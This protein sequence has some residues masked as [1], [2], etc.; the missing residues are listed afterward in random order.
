MT[1]LLTRHPA[2]RWAIGSVLA[3]IVLAAAYHWLSAREQADDT[4]NQQIG[5]QQE[6]GEAAQATI[7]Q[8]RKANDAEQELRSDDAV[9]RASCLR[10]SRNPENCR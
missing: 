2:L 4:T 9:R 10:H 6:R 5:I 8:A 3:I 7:Q 1:W